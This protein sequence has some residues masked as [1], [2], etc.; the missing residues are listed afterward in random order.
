MAMELPPGLGS[1][2][3]ALPPSS[4]A[5]PRAGKGQNHRQNRSK[6]QVLSTRTHLQ[7]RLG[8]LHHSHRTHQTQPRIQGGWWPCHTSNNQY[9]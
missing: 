5:S 1:L 4:A 7:W 6:R 9:L 3:W 2:A 8:G